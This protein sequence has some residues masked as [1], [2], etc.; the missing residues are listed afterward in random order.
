MLQLELLC[1]IGIFHCENFAENDRTRRTENSGILQIHFL[2]ASTRDRILGNTADCEVLEVTMVFNIPGLSFLLPNFLMKARGECGRPADIRFEQFLNGHTSYVTFLLV[3][4]GFLLFNELVVSDVL[5]P[6]PLVETL[7]TSLMRYISVALRTVVCCFV[8]LTCYIKAS[9]V[10][11]RSGQ[12]LQK[13]INALPTIQAL[14]PLLM[15][16]AFSFYIICDKFICTEIDRP[17]LHD[18]AV[19]LIIAGL[20]AYPMVTFMLL[21]DKRQIAVIASW[22]IGVVTHLVVA[23]ESGSHREMVTFFAYTLTSGAILLD[24]Y[25]QNRVVID[26]ITSLQNTLAENEEMSAEVQAQELRAMIGNVAHDLKTVRMFYPTICVVTSLM[27][28]L[29]MYCCSR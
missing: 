28:A 27:R 17:K 9:K 21:R 12:L 1:C 25:R 20:K 2:R 23:V 18:S 15:N 10:A 5:V 7:P 8:A 22:L 24:C 26:L 19:Y 14:Y 3:L 4:L 13:L 29:A 11:T 6:S 16:L